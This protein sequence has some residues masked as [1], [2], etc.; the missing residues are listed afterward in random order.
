MIYQKLGRPI[1][2]M[3]IGLFIICILWRV[4]LQNRFTL[5]IPEPAAMAVPD[6]EQGSM[7]E[8]VPEGE[9]LVEFGDP[10]GSNGL[11][12]VEV[13]PKE[14]LTPGQEFY[15]V[16]RPEEGISELHVLHV[17]RFG[18]IYDEAS[19]NFTGDTI[20][21]L[22]VAV[23]F[24]GI[25]V[26]ML[27][28]FLQAREE[29]IYSYYTV[30]TSGFSLFAGITGILLLVLLAQHMLFPYRY[31]MRTVF[32]GVTYAS[33]NFII[34]TA[35]LILVFSVLMV[36]SNAELLRHEPPR[37]RNVLGILA[38]FLLLAG[39]GLGIFLKT[40][41]FMGSYRE[42]LIRKTL[43][44]VYCTAYVYFECM[45]AGAVIC[46][47]R[48][49]RHNPS[50]DRDY[51]II[52]GCRFR[53]DGT[54]TPLLKGR[55]DRAVTFWKEQKEK[56][57]KEAVLIPSGGQG[58][59]ESMPEAE[60]M[61]RYLLTCGVPEQNILPETRSRNTFQNMSFSKELIEKEQR[62]K[63]AK[64]GESREARVVF[65]TTNYHVFRSGVWASMAGLK[66]EGIG[67]GTKWWFW[68]NAF[69]RECVGLLV[70][71]IRQEAFMLILLAFFF[72]LMTW[73]FGA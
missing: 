72:A 39:A 57:G 62:E 7:V 38:A 65:S 17:G 32:E 31:N 52:L 66:A 5:H 29:E 42:L 28:Y 33:M 43:E 61:K 8:F 54:L 53:R 63:R 45:L 70:N 23:F 12:E 4:A 59:D 69:L 47:L 50:W 30:Y 58:T 41:D 36:I 22:A 34:L 27:K 67:S 19:G 51:I 40:R 18:T 10:A 24:L 37:F 56:T 35:P 55:C 46:G 14:P 60:A 68:P 49:A 6:A 26:L 16:N 44:N 3:T 20:V 64:G 73:L 2:L 13:R 71:R 9:E 15:Y 21:L 25:A 1:L 11:I 48:A